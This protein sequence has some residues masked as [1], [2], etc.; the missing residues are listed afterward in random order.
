MYNRFTND[1]KKVLQYAQDAAQ[2]FRHNYVGTEH[3]LLGL[4]LNRSGLAGQLLSQLGL[5]SDNVSRAIEQSIGL[6]SVSPTELRLTPRTKQAM[7]LAVS[8]A[9][10]LGQSYVGTEHILAG[11]LQEGSGMAIRILEGMDIAPDAVEQK[12]NDLMG[13]SPFD[14]EDG[15]MAPGQIDLND[16]GR[17]LNEMAKLGKIDPVIGRKNE[18]NRVIQILCRRTK[19]NPVLIGAPGVGKT[20]IAEGLAQRITTGNVPDILLQKKI[21]S[22]DLASLVAGTNTAANLKNG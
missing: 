5:T 3:I 15:E 1:A 18:I 8:E 10:R 14:E 21:F 16:F 11:L 9:N 13:G 4:V 7:E 22:L 6:G 2:K 17:D 19:N 12:L 20:A